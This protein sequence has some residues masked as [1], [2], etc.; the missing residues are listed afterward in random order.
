MR[1]IDTYSYQCGIIECF[2]EMVNAGLKPLALAHP[3]KTMKQRELYI[4]FVEEICKKYKTSYY[5]EDTPLLTDLFPISL[6]KN[7]YNILF[8]Q[9]PSVLDQ[10]LQLK[11]IKQAALTQGNYDQVR[12]DIAYKF[13]Y[14][15]NYPDKRI[16]DFINNNIEKE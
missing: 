13:G 8:Y 5:L 10:Y 1:K 16:L 6:N 3:F 11:E 15:L 2:N 12:K 9:D 7:T 14:L 4:E